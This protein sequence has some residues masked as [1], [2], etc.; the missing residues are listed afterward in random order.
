MATPIKVVKFGRQ[1][2]V[3]MD[4]TTSY[5][6]Y[7]TNSSLWLIG[8]ASVTPTG[9][10]LWPFSLAS[11]NPANGYP[12]DW[13]HTAGRPTHNGGDFG[14]GGASYGVD[15]GCAGAGTVIE[16]RNDAG[17]ADGSGSFGNYALVDHGELY[18]G[19]NYKTLYAHMIAGSVIA[20]GSPV[21]AGTTLGL[22]GNSG[23]SFGAHL[24]FETH[25]NDVPISMDAFMSVYNPTG[26]FVR[27]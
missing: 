2:K 1:L 18:P 24:H 10:F 7:P 23:G 13:F 26:A 15:V 25:E 19:Q 20:V 11:S 27:P 5:I 4:D 14:Y 22:V 9:D 3:I 17:D 16:N 6:A 12:D 21:V 8:G